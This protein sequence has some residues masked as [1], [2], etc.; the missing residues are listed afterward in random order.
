VDSNPHRISGVEESDPDTVATVLV[1]LIGTVLLVAA[2]ALLQGLYDNVERR[3]LRLKVVLT[4]PE[5][6]RA[7]RVKQLEQL[8]ATAWV[9][10]AAG[11]VAI[12]VDRAMELI[13][14][15]PSLTAVPPKPA[16]TP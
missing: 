1:G 7:L 13:V 14:R 2:V 11:V 9:D 10:H 4:T 15:N 6:I 8:K 12:P 16:G 3:E 5:E